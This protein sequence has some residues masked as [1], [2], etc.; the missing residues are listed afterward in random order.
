MTF[1]IDENLSFRLKAMLEEPFPGCRHV[2][3]FGLLREDDPVIHRKAREE[4]L[5]ILTKDD[6]FRALVA[7]AG[8][9]PKLVMLNLGNASTATNAAVLIAQR[10]VI[11]G[12][13][14]DPSVSI[15]EV[16][17]ADQD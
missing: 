16:G 14:A 6:D 9:P 10:D 3:D 17:L 15:L 11:A 13:L 8:P 12:F 2:A 1:L 4:G 7:A 5:V